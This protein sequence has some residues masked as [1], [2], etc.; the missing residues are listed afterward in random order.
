[1]M[2]HRVSPQALIAKL[3]AMV[4][5]LLYGGKLLERLFWIGDSS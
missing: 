5:R 2:R 1:M 3:T 4:L